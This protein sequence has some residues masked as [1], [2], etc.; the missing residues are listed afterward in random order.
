[1]QMSDITYSA[2]KDSLTVVVDGTA[3][4]VRK[5]TAN[6]EKLKRALFEERWAEVPGL[7]TVEKTV[8]GWAQG[9][10]KV[11]NKAIQFKGSNVP[12]AISKRIMAMITKDEDPT[13]LLRFYERLDRNPSMRSVESLFGFLNH[14][15]IPI[16]PDGT[17]LTYK[18]VRSD[19]KDHHSGTVDY[20][21]SKDGEDNK[22]V[23]VP[24][25]K[26]SDDPRTACHFGLH[27]GAYKYASGFG[28][29]GKIIICRID[30]EHVVCV[31]Y[32]SNAEKMRVCVLEVVGF[33]N[34]RQMP[35][36]TMDT[37]DGG[38]LSPQRRNE[39]VPADEDDFDPDAGY[40]DDYEEDDED[41]G[42]D[43]DDEDDLSFE[44]DELD[45]PKPKAEKPQGARGFVVTSEHVAYFDDLDTKDE[46][47]LLDEPLTNEDGFDLRKYATYRVKV[48]GAS[49]IPG[50]KAALVRNII[51]VRDGDGH[52]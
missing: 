24:R 19:C 25:N 1:M 22:V 43:E 33:W 3:S 8:E 23:T 34:G 51:E 18:S 50:G 17:F 31:P 21:P 28:A 6:Y 32:D 47:D 15:G 40:D 38:A 45:L 11:V 4:V 48:V 44:D 52:K 27:V 10:F 26:V 13:P 41:D 36:T 49:K 39:P 12:D 16:E 35:S 46:V 29:G 2:T 7:L 30:P 20:T 37:D 14:Q 5:G 42:Y 9:E